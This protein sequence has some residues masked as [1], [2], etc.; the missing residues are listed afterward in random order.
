MLSHVPFD[1]SIRPETL[2]ERNCLFFFPL[3]TNYLHAKPNQRLWVPRRAGPAAALVL[4]HG[5]GWVTVLPPLWPRASHQGLTTLN[6][7]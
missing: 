6:Q 5:L 1:S 4:L 2:Q 3:E 7:Q